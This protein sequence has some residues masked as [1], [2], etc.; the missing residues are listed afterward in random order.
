[1]EQSQ[2]L[3]TLGQLLDLINQAGLMVLSRLA[4]LLIGLLLT[5]ISIWIIRRRM[6]ALR[7]KVLTAP[8]AAV[9]KA[10]KSGVQAALVAKDA[11]SSAASQTGSM[12]QTHAGPV[13]RRAGKAAMGSAKV[14][15]ELASSAIEA[16][17]PHAQTATTV[18]VDALR[19]GASH[20]AA[21]APTVVNV[22]SSALGVVRTGAA[23]TGLLVKLRADE[24]L[25]HAVAE[26][27]RREDRTPREGE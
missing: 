15:V 5:L 4:P 22:A 18:T 13:A 23:A 25:E 9:G 19:S 6:R 10:A 16:A 12:I 24:L 21:A 1:M 27:K 8:V 20:L 2:F 11:L 17:S 3:Q 7:R 26:K 14:G